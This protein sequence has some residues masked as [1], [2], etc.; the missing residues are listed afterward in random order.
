MNMDREH[1]MALGVHLMKQDRRVLE[2]LRTCTFM[3]PIMLWIGV[4]LGCSSYYSFRD[5][6]AALLYFLLPLVAV[7][8]LNYRRLSLKRKL[9][10]QINK[11]YRSARDFN[12]L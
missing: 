9:E 5:P 2:F 3:E 10:Y 6:V 4:L 12:R 11:H 8:A 7:T 1:R